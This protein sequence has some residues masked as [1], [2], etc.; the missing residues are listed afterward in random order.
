MARGWLD[1]Q[2]LPLQDKW[3]YKIIFLKLALYGEGNYVNIRDLI[4]SI[5]KHC[6][7]KINVIPSLSLLALAAYL[8]F[9]SRVA[10]PLSTLLPGTMVSPLI[11]VDLGVF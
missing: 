11:N 2:I 9:S 3:E 4:H 6:K 7:R 5:T 8:L 10:V 1:V